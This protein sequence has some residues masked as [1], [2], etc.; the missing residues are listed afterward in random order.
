[1]S[2]MQ[3]RFL[4]TGCMGCLGAW[5][6][7]R[8]L[9]EGSAVFA[10]DLSDDRRRLELIASSEELQR[11][12]FLRG[13]I[14]DSSTVLDAMS[15]NNITHVIHLAALQ[16]P[17]VRANPTLGSRVNV[18]GT[19]NIF[20]AAVALG[21][22]IRGVVYASAA[23]VFGPPEMYPGG[24]V[25]DDSPRSPSTL[26]GVYKQTNEDAARIYWSELGL[27]T[28]GLRPWI[29]YGP[30]RDQGMT[31]GATV[32]MLAAAARRPYRIGFGGESI[33][34]YAPDVASVFVAAARAGL[35]GADVFNVGGESAAV[36]RVV[37]ILETV[38]P[39][40]RGLITFD[41][42][43]IGVVAHISDGGLDAKIGSRRFTPLAEGIEL[44]VRQFRTLLA[45]GAVN[46]P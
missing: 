16:V 4:V 9:D 31:S 38:E 27:S 7:K 46:P 26:Y 32:A 35:S 3:E 10:F 8:L 15:S 30:G 12:T 6:V 18:T 21:E 25:S 20:E 45:V 43:T 37:E 1:M 13:D 19:I 14:T 40:S 34:Q 44:T 42:T 33:F 29:I 41:S 11:V 5:T 28:V 17:F 24:V 2:E 36:A 22:Q 23:A 39:E